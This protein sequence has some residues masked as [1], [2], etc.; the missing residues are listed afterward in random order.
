MVTQLPD[1]RIA[2][3]IQVGLNAITVDLN[4]PLAGLSRLKR[5]PPPLYR[6]LISLYRPLTVT[7]TRYGRAIRDLCGGDRRAR[8]AAQRPEGRESGAQHNSYKRSIPRSSDQFTRV[9]RLLAISGGRESGAQHTFQGFRVSAKQPR[10][11]R[12]RI[13]SDLVRLA[14]AGGIFPLTSCG[15]L[16]S[17]Y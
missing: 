9:R 11:C 15:W 16:P 2:K 4:H 6:P 10:G 17:A 12:P 1:G 5:A 14:R 3:V 7:L 8:A 13:P